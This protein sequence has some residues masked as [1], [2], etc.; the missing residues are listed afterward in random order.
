MAEQDTETSDAPE[1]PLWFDEIRPGGDAE[2]FLERRLRHSLL[3]VQRPVKRLLVTFDNLSN[4]SDRSPGRE[5]WAF[6]F[7]KDINISH[8]GVMAH[9]ADWYRDS[10][11]IERFQKLADEGFFEGYDRVIFAG[12]SMGGYAAIA[13]GSLVPGAH[14]ISVNPQSTL[15]T[16]IVPWETRYEG[17]RRQDWTLPLSDAS[18]LTAKLERVNIFYDPYH[19]LDKQHVSRF[20]G[21]NI[22]VFNCRH[23]NHKTAVFLRKINALK[24]VMQAA[25]FDEL[26]EVEFYRLYR[27]RR[28]LRWYKGAVVA[29]FREQ[30]RDELADRFG[31]AFRKRL[32]RVQRQEDHDDLQASEDVDATSLDF[33]SSP[34]EPT[35]VSATKLANTRNVSDAEK[36]KARCAIV[37]TMKNEGPF[38]LEWVAFHRT[39]GFN[40]FLIYTNDC[41]DGTDK[42]AQRL[43]ELGLANHVDNKFKK[44]AS[45]Q[46]VALRRALA[47]DVYK[48]ADWIICAD[49]DEFLNIRVGDGTLSALFDAVGQADAISFCWKLFGCGGHVAFQDEF[50]H[51]NFTWSA[52][53]AF[54]EKYRGLGLKTIF[55]PSEAIRKFGVH[56]PKFHNRPEG[57]VWK[58]AGGKPMPEPYFGTGWSAYAKFD[59][60]FA[61]LHHYA[62]RSV[63]SFL[64]KRDRGR[65]NHIDRDQGVAYWADMNLNMEEDVSLV[66][67]AGRTRTEFDAMMKDKELRRL[68]YEACAWHRAKVT[69]L[70]QNKEWSSFYDLLQTINK[71]GEA[72]VNRDK[73]LEDLGV[74]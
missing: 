33:T 49:C 34:P 24:P 47:H 20:E 3:F 11:L 54:R 14:V 53:E 25:I 17:G 19:E 52:P 39:L 1:L 72:P 8:L 22:R 26:D 71:R 27:G 41:E 35:T 66:A 57:F 48:S 6:K 4:V 30:G 43:E 38:M 67:A 60:S 15:D 16:D 31:M 65:T 5:P 45:P 58:D 13:F 42:I 68:H 50:I 64:V 9:V 56:R 40:D 36:R 29:Y 63:D 55:R 59:H 51:E 10:D 46:R 73:L 18:K 28:D 32:R 7:A 70:K 37:T 74:E 44:G 23:S 61:R 2:G 21:D 69:A 12:V 62:V